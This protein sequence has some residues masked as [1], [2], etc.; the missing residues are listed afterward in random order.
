MLEKA[1]RRRAGL[2]LGASAVVAIALISII[3][4]GVYETANLG[5]QWSTAIVSQTSTSI[6]YTTESS[7]EQYTTSIESNSP[8]SVETTNSSLGLK[9]VLSVNSTMILSEDAIN[10][11]VTIVNLLPSS[12]NL[13]TENDWPIQRLISGPC[14]FGT[15]AGF[16][17]FR[18][19]YEMNNLS[20]A[21]S[22]LPIWAEILCPAE[23]PPTIFENGT[24][25]PRLSYSSQIYAANNTG[26]YNSLNSSL[27]ATYT[28]VGGDEWG[29]IVLLHFSVTPSHNLLTVGNFLSSPSE[30]G[31]AENGVPTPC[32]SSDFVA[33]LNLTARVKL[34]RLQVAPII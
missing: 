34:Q 26:F 12:N 28:L 9:L 32:L 11:T 3:G 29:Q 23:S 20:S 22:A 5:A 21:G 30:G 18:G 27:P 10:M 2:S 4:F 25:L 6:S 1:P 13:T 8:I 19:Y 15:P 17:V 24:L 31:C 16:A 14:D 7:E 33:T